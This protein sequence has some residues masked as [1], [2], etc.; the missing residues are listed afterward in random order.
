LQQ[1]GIGNIHS[2]PLPTHTKRLFLVYHYLSHEFIDVEPE[3]VIEPSATFEITPEY[4]SAARFIANPSVIVQ[5][6]ARSRLLHFS[7]CIFPFRCEDVE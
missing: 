3:T 6:I 1:P 7:S 4:S 2:R 5:I